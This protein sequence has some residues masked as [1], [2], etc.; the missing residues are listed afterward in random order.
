MKFTPRKLH[1]AMLL[2]SL[3]AILS[4]CGGGGGG[5]GGAPGTGG[6][7]G[8]LPP[9]DDSRY[10]ILS[11]EAPLTREDGSCLDG[12]ESY[13]ISYGLSPGHYENTEV[14]KVEDIKPSATGRSTECGDVESYT[15]LVENL[16]PASWYFAVRA[17]DT[18]GEVSSYSNEVFRTVE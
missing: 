2:A 15:Y 1:Q 9:K 17:V 7:A 12:L 14:V 16:S 13:D 11:W 4:A 8:V 6:G 5:G 18:N 3:S 10:V